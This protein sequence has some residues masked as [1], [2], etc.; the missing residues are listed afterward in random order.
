[1]G[2]LTLAA[3]FLDFTDNFP[4][5]PVRSTYIACTDYPDQPDF[6]GMPLPKW[7]KF[8]GKDLEL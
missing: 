3:A 2:A 8:G 5:R 7:L 6:D 4:C 1:M